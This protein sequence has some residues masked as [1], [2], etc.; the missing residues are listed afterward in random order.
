MLVGTVSIETSERLSA[1]LKRRG[2][3][4]QVLNA[5]Y[6]EQEAEII[7]QA[8]KKGA[9]T[10]ATNMAGR[11]T[12]I[13]LGG[14]PEFLA[15]QEMRKRGYTDEQIAAAADLTAANPKG[16]SGGG[17]AAVNGASDGGDWL[18]QAHAEYR[19]LVEEARLRL[20][21]EQEQVR[22]LGGLH[23]IG[24][25]RHESRRIDNQLRGRAGRQGDPGSSRFYV[26]LEDDLM[27]LFGSDRITGIMERLGWD[28]DMPIEHNQISK[29]IENAQ[30]RVEARNFEARK[31]VLQFDDVMNKQREVIYDQRR[32][33]L[34]G[35]N[36][37]ENVVDMVR[38]LVED[39]VDTYCDEKLHAEEWDLPALQE[40]VAD[41]INRPAEQL[42][43]PDLFGDDAEGLQRDT[44][45][46]RLQALVTAAYEERER[47]FGP[48]L[49]R[50][51]ERHFLLQIMD[52]KWM[53]HLRAMDDLREGI[54][55]R[56]YGQRNPLIEY[57]I[58]AFEMFQGMMGSIQEDTV[59]AL[60]R[61]RV[62]GEE[63]PSMAA[64]ADLLSRAT[65]FHG[66]DATTAGAGSLT[67][68]GQGP[69][70]APRVQQRRVTQRVGRNDPCPCGSGK[71]Y[72]HCCGRAG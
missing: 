54:G 19:A 41:L 67:R 26:S 62:R 22:A 71:K 15:R 36:L 50:Q 61:V 56:A 6:H 47:E 65:A 52:L 42:Q 17:A 32:K 13:V 30:K 23:I 57:Q 34:L 8:G 4:H 10:I 53:E 29:A 14:N 66:G 64:G 21:P 38:R 5:K 37:R 58:E 25:E 60:F 11:G 1:V 43:A 69:Q 72:K 20:A 27:R 3:P 24:T 2:I 51:I 40:R 33:V 28:E 9:V 48:E 49:M 44:L 46:E 16:S 68:R 35:E 63:G 18:A 31:Q 59:K 12:D 7:A 70:E 55:L 39:Y 45:K